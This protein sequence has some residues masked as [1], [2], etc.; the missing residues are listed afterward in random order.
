MGEIGM[1]YITSSHSYSVGEDIK[2]HEV[3]IA[4][5]ML[6]NYMAICLNPCWIDVCTVLPILLIHVL[7]ISTE[8]KLECYTLNFKL[9]LL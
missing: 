8:V 7:C 9:F 3:C 2:K 6:A 4:A 5:H 1:L